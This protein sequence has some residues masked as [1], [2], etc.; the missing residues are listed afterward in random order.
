MF[1]KNAS[2]LVL[3]RTPSFFR[4]VAR[5]L[6]FVP[7]PRFDVSEVDR[8]LIFF[9]PKRSV[10]RDSEFV[11]SLSELCTPLDAIPFLLSLLALPVP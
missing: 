6:I 1:R 10:E 8:F 7:F 11:P 5:S 2:R 9:L 4:T 3:D